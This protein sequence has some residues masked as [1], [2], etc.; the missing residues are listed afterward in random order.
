[1]IQPFVISKMLTL[2]DENITSENQGTIYLYA[3]LL[4]LS[5]LLSILSYHYFVFQIAQ[6]GMKMR[7]ACSSLIYRKSLKLSQMA[8]GKTS[9]GQIVNLLSND[10]GRLENTIY[11]NHLFMAPLETIL[12]IILMYM[13]IGWYGLIG[14]GFMVFSMFIS[15]ESDL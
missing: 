6:I 15:C 5:S 14:T 4:V 11:F 12:V 13:S 7:I 3:T 1:M 9:A 8:F 2:Y 10:V